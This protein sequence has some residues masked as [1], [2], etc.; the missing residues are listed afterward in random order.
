M[1]RGPRQAR[2]AKEYDFPPLP[3]PL[4]RAIGPRPY[5]ILVTGVGGTG[6][7][8]I[9]AILDAFSL[10]AAAAAGRLNLHL[11]EFGGIANTLTH[12]KS[13]SL[14]Y[15]VEMEVPNQEPLCYDLKISPKGHS[16]AIEHEVLS[17]LQPPDTSP[18]KH[19]DSHY[20]IVR[21]N[22][23][24]GKETDEP[25]FDHYDPVETALSQVPRFL[26]QAEDL[27][28]KLASA[29]LYH[30]LD[31]GPRSPVKLPQQLRPAQLPGEEG[32]DSGLMPV[33]HAGDRQRPFR[34]DR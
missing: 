18:F 3:Q 9:G 30:V 24:D 5:G 22:K 31:V 12:D 20:D 16:Y 21:Y 15:S 27:R 4:I 11:S 13:E 17:Q 6:V 14:T 1:A 34:S 25:G 7:V 10:L 19:I 29:T 32:E 2:A 23:V 8:T 33:Q 28:R 26:R